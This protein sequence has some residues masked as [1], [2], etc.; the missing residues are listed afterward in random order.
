MSAYKLTI[1]QRKFIKL[2][3]ETGNAS[4]SA[5]KAGYK[6]GE[7]GRENLRKLTDNGLFDQLLDDFDLGDGAIT[8]ALSEGLKATKPI[9]C[10]VYIENDDGKMEM[11]D[12]DGLSKDFIEVEDYSTRHKY[13]ET[14]LKLRQKIRKPAEH[15]EAKQGDLTL[16]FINLI[17]AVNT[18]KEFGGLDRLKGSIDQDEILNRF[19]AK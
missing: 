6:H 13:L 5:L 11:K 7:S 16:N 12:A 9:S 8:Q 1:K 3:L 2:Y 15:E 10:N 4:A 17:N 19:V 18:K 14:L